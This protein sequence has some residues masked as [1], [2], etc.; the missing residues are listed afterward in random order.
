MLTLKNP[1][2]TSSTGVGWLRQGFDERWQ[3]AVNLRSAVL[4]A[5]LGL[6]RFGQLVI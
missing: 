4:L 3:R 1:T 2:T 6:W 5:G